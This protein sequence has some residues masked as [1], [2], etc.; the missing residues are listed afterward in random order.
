VSEAFCPAGISSF[1][2]ICNFDPSTG[3][4]I[5]D[6]ARIGARGGGFAIAR[7]VKARVSVKNS[8]RNQI[9]IHIHSRPDLEGQTTRW[10]LERVLEK[11][12]TKLNVRADIKVD[13]PIGAGYGSS[14]AGTAA[15]C[16]AL[17]DAAGISTTY[18]ELGRITHVAEVVNRTGLGTAAAVFVGGFVLV[19]EPGAPGVG[20]VDRLLFPKDHSII[21]AFLEPLPTRDAL[22]RMDLASKV[23]PSAQRAMKKILETSDLRTFLSESRRFGQEIGLESPE[24][25]RLI[26]T[27]IS[28]GAV[29]AAQN[30]VGIAA[31]GVVENAK[32]VRV[33]RLLKKRFSSAVVFASCLDETGVR[34]MT[35]RKPKH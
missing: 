23:N 31:H 4:E 29:G 2:E 1:F 17:A 26:D 7:G 5:A 20:A 33:V 35:T 8:D 16:L 19:T 3:E 11:S 10:G 9:E 25:T 18:N 30:M 24:V 22:A 21:C 13:V 28:G 15:A 34:L 32:A 12:T 27:M 14:A 6:P